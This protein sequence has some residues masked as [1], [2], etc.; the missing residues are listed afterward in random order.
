VTGVR[1]AALF[2]GR[3]VAVGSD[4]L[5]GAVW[6]SS[7]GILWRR[8][9]QH[10][11]LDGL[12]LQHLAVGPHELVALADDAELGS[13]AMLVSHDGI[14]WSTSRMAP[15]TSKFGQTRLRGVLY[16]RGHFVAFG[17]RTVSD[18][19]VCEALPT[20]VWR[21]S[22]GVAWSV[23]ATV[24][25]PE[26][27]PARPAISAI[28][29]DRYGYLAIG[30]GVWTSAD[31]IHWTLERR[32]PADQRVLRVFKSGTAFIGVRGE[33]QDSVVLWS[34]DA[35]SWTEA[36]VPARDV[37]IES[38][39]STAG[40][41]V[42]VGFR[43]TPFAA[44]TVD[45]QTHDQPVLWT[46]PDG[47]TWTDI[48]IATP[49]DSGRLESVVEIAGRAIALGTRA[50]APSQPGDAAAW[51]SPSDH[52]SEPSS[53]SVPVSAGTWSQLPAFEAPAPDVGVAALGSMWL[54]PQDSQVFIAYEVQ[55][56]TEGGDVI[57]VTLWD[58]AA[59]RLTQDSRISHH[60]LGAVVVS[61]S[62]RIYFLGGSFVDTASLVDMFDIARRRWATQRRLRYDAEYAIGSLVDPDHVLIL[63]QGGMF[64]ITDLGT[65][66]DIAGTIPFGAVPVTMIPIGRHRTLVLTDA[67]AWIFDSESHKW[68][69]GATAPRVGGGEF[70]TTTLDGR[71]VLLRTEPQPTAHAWLEVISPDRR[72]WREFQAPDLLANAIGVIGAGD[73]SL[74]VLTRNETCDADQNCYP[75]AMV[76]PYR[77]VGVVPTQ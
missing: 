36:S 37:S 38:V 31:A 18:C 22:D 51:S 28:F 44:G 17:E 21:S 56:D 11:A 2:E 60:H 6:S 61:T 15:F 9:P 27:Q 32:V 71:I 75:D 7:D 46:S 12:P 59:G 33:E 64:R 67:R 25:P 57:G 39:V 5:G 34:D 3:I 43:T 74:L 23:A 29:A 47:R 68:T 49:D 65:L 73:G 13:P 72:L 20:T 62:R 24:V 30:S 26:K 58:P 4:P 14:A 70:V 41:L 69:P 48:P 53:P 55:S 42:A 19:G 40:G 10:E 77:G 35:R 52:T 8:E 50:P 76:T 54:F 63:L 16:G 1:D 66:R 45:T